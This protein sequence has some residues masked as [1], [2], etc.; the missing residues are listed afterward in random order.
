[1]DEQVIARIRQ[2]LSSRETENLLE[3]WQIHDKDQWTEDA[4]EAVR[5]ILLTRMETLPPF[6]DRQEADKHLELAAAYNQAN[7]LAKAL[8]ECS[9]AIRFAPHYAQPYNDRGMVLDG[10]DRPAEAAESF[11]EALRLDPNLASAREFLHYAKK[12]TGQKTVGS[13]D[14]IPAAPQGE[15]P[16]LVSQEERIMA[17]FSHITV[18]LPMLGIIVPIVFWA[19]QKDKSRY[20]AFQAL[21]AAVYQFVML[22]AYFVGGACYIIS[23]FGIFLGASFDRTPNPG[24]FPVGLI[25]LPFIVFGVIGLGGLAFLSYAVI[26][27]VQSFRGKDFRYLLIGNFLAKRLK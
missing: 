23:F 22:F 25:V 11:E 27:A 16:P 2:E 18:L 21:Q 8:D 26:G 3:I 13:Q 4:L 6:E 7:E 14:Q 5:Q 15:R 17:A 12:E 10:L 1:M 19:T 9:L 24:S 20:V